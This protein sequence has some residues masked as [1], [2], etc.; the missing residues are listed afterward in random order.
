M[1]TKSVTALWLCFLLSVVTTAHSDTCPPE[2]VIGQYY[3]DR[4]GDML[5]DPPLSSIAW[6]NPSTLVWAFSP[7]EDPAIYAELLKPFTEHLKSCTGRQIVYYPIQTSTAEIEAMRTGRLHFAGFSTGS[8][9]VAVEQAGAV[10]FATKGVDDQVRGYNLIAVV[11]DSSSYTQLS[12]LAGKRIAHATP[13]SNSGNIAPRVFFPKNGLVPDI[14]YIPIMSGGHDKSLLGLSNGD[15]DMAAVASDVYARMIERGMID[16]NKLRVI[17]E[18]SLFPT[19]SFA[20]AHDLHPDLVKQLSDCFYNFQFTSEMQ[21][22]FN[23]DT[24]FI[25][26]DYKESWAPVREVLQEFKTIQE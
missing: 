4:D 25:P 6:R 16:E 7:I 20:H 21:A 13:L 24:N 2:A 5:P 18:S 8:T 11:R 9:V 26:V 12:D 17:Y 1:K 19:S 22:A 14:D 15:Y 23:G 10:P 3:C